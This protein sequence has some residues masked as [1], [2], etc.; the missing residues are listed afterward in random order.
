MNIIIATVKLK[1]RNVRRTVL[2]ITI[3]R[4]VAVS[5]DPRVYKMVCDNFLFDRAPD[6]KNSSIS[7][8]ELVKATRSQE[9]RIPYALVFAKK[10]QLE[11]TIRKRN[12]MVFGALGGRTQIIGARGSLGNIMRI[13]PIVQDLIAK[14]KHFDQ[15][16]D[17]KIPDKIIKYLSN[18]SGSIEKQAE[19][20]VNKMDIDMD[21]FR[22]KGTKREAFNY[23]KERLT[24]KSIH[25]AVEAWNCMP[26][27]IP[28]EL[29]LSGLYLRSNTNP[30]IF[31]ANERQQ[32]PD[33]GPA[34]KIYTMLYLLVSI[35]KG[36]GHAVHID[37][38]YSQRY[39]NSK[40]G[41]SRKLDA[42]KIVNKILLPS[43]SMK[44]I[45]VKNYDSVD[46]AAGEY[47]VSVVALL[48][49]LKTLK[50]IEPPQYK[51][52]KSKADEAFRNYMINEREK[53][54]KTT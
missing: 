34:R 22:S 14:Q 5:I 8:R 46:E 25:V 35:F 45:D 2:N 51:K 21:T 31:V 41:S 15:Y 19:Y 16:D 29:T 4:Q 12:D 40:S 50:L 1:G 43:Q 20:V 38:D 24:R 10:S 7:F 6:I 36:V 42:H 9:V 32:H 52:F 27:N 39:D 17:K 37:K 48:A 53:R 33:E 18:S 47:K 28:K 44:T 13:A 49:R 26:I 23:L 54:K 11:E 30:S 3:S